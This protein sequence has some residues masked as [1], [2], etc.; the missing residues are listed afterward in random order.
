MFQ[1]QIMSPSSS[2]PGVLEGNSPDGQQ[3][4][5]QGQPL[6]IPQS[7]T[8]GVSTGGYYSPPI[9]N[10]TIGPNPYAP[11]SGFP[12]PPLD[13]ST[14][15]QQQQQFYQSYYNN[16]GGSF[17]FGQAPYGFSPA[18][19]TP[20]TT[21]MNNN[22]PGGAQ[23]SFVGPQIPVLTQQQQQQQQFSNVVGTSAPANNYDAALQLS[24]VTQ[25]LQQ[26]QGKMISE[27][28]SK[29]SMVTSPIKDE[30]DASTSEGVVVVKDKQEQEDK[31]AAT[32]TSSSEKASAVRPAASSTGKTAIKPDSE[33][34]SSED[35][36][37]VNKNDVQHQQQNKPLVSPFK[38][39]SKAAIR[40]KAER[41]Y[42]RAEK[43][44]ADAGV[45]SAQ[46]NAAKELLGEVKEWI[47][48]YILAGSSTSKGHRGVLPGQEEDA[49]KELE[50]EVDTVCMSSQASAGKHSDANKQL[51]LL[52][53]ATTISSSADR[54]LQTPI[55]PADDTLTRGGEPSFLPT[56]VG[57]GTQDCKTSYCRG[58]EDQ[59]MLR[60]LKTREDWL[61]M[62]TNYGAGCE[63]PDG[64]RYWIRA[65][66]QDQAACTDT[67]YFR[68][69]C[70]N[71]RVIVPVDATP[72]G[73][74]CDKLYGQRNDQD[75][76]LF[77]MAVQCSAN[78]LPVSVS[79]DSASAASFASSPS[80]PGTLQ[81]RLVNNVYR[82]N[83]FAEKVGAHPLYP[84]RFR[85]GG[86]CRCPNG[87]EYGVSSRDGCATLECE[88]GMVMSCNRWEDRDAWSGH[89]VEC[90]V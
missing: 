60:D 63:C 17:G 39:G 49:L 59:Q 77:V 80:S 1:E 78:T 5:P 24:K 11:G 88:N 69:R 48:D 46:K 6:F 84:D 81:K 28:E 26:G 86:Y 67:A 66:S 73:G 42:K 58:A 19:F 56:P 34:S 36:R 13:A 38:Q 21:M 54:S 62:N 18:W 52:S 40:R 51:A 57:S 70:T 64:T 8:T 85:F 23:S 82:Q 45:G 30:K 61:A 10:P 3:I 43:C 83:V 55:P 27:A 65:Q 37:V 74:I 2:Y 14:Q 35:N 20:S 53:L 22:Q 41:H 71:G 89:A 29:S 15:Q 7:S 32:P 25:G 44:V 87:E 12:T 33:S 72:G 47:N 79:A 68:E 75:V 90:A 16:P 50:A 31:K 76:D 9:Q 4:A